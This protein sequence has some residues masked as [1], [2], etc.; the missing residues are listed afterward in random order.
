M[1]KRCQVAFSHFYF[2]SQ[3]WIVIGIWRPWKLNFK[4]GI[5]SRLTYSGGSA[6]FS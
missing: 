3:S 2:V 6:T 4:W 5:E 1:G